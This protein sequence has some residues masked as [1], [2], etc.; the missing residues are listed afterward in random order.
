MDH[1]DPINEQIIESRR[2]YNSKLFVDRK[3]QLDLVEERVG[4]A[5]TNKFIPSPLVNFWGV[6]GIGKTWL[7]RYLND[8]Y[9][10]PRKEPEATFSLFYAF[11]DNPLSQQ[12]GTVVRTLANEIFTQ[13]S[14]TIATD[15]R[16]DLRLAQDLGD[17]T[18]F[19]DALN[20]SAQQLTPLLLLDNTEHI[21]ASAWEKIEQE[22]LE[23][24]IT[25]NRIIVVIAGRRQIPRWRRFEV[26]R[27]V[28]EYDRTR[29]NPLAKTDIGKQLEVSRYRNIS[30]DWLYAHTGGNPYLVDILARQA[31]QWIE[32]NKDVADHTLIWEQHRSQLVQILKESEDG[33]LESVVD[34]E[35][36]IALYAVI[37]LRFYRLEA[38]RYM[39]SRQAANEEPDVY[40]LTL[41]RRL[42]QETEVVWWHRDRRA[43]VTSEVVR[44]VINRRHLL[45]EPNDLVLNHRHACAMY[46]NWIEDYPQASEDFIIELYFHLGN[47][48]LA[49]QNFDE[50][51]QESL[52]VLS[53][54]EK[55]L[56]PDRLIILQKAFDEQMGDREL[57]DLL[58][59]VLVLE[60]RQKIYEILD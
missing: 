30:V 3:P 17:A 26:R 16:D 46:W 54:A 40:Y 51:H 36:R 55:E 59:E 45:E 4:S 53:Y 50:L 41:L 60:L 34:K 35:L 20:A 7:L 2:I 21:P 22:L 58:P 1:N 32:E 25:S 48:Y 15:V 33:Q 42:D 37:P 47:I 13:L 24:L 39:C 31:T 18:A 49:K 6:K 19:V 5:Y 12:V 23:P 9:Q 29:I 27:R 10:Y 11:E 14:Q 57:L 8:K 56:N 44:L 28:V 43:Y 38:M 52:K